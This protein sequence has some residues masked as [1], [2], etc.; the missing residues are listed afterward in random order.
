MP[1]SKSPIATN[2]DH[3]ARA[4]TADWTYMSGTDALISALIA[5][6]SLDVRDGLNT[7]GFVSGYRGSPVAGLDRALWKAS[8]AL[9]R[10][11]IT[12]VP[13]LNEELA[14]V[15]VLGS[16]KVESDPA[17]AVDGVFGLWYGKGPG[18][19]R[20]GDAIKHGNAYGASPNGGVL[21]VVGDDHGCVSSSMS[22]Q[23]DLALMG[24]SMP[25]IHPP[26]V[27]E[28]VSLALWGWACSRTSGCWL[29]FK[30]ISSVIESSRSVI[31]TDLPTFI[32]PII[33][34]DA[35]G[36]HW[37][38]PDLPST[39]IEERL[40]YKLAAARA[41]AASNPIDRQLSSPASTELVIVAVGKA[42]GD[43]L[44][45][46]DALEVS[47][48]DL[49]K[50]GICLLSV[51]LVF[52]LSPVLEALARDARKVLVV[53]EKAAVVETLLKDALFN[54]P[55]ERR[56]IIVGKVNEFGQPL[57]PTSEL[58]GSTIL[59]VISVF[60]GS[61]GISV[62]NRSERRGTVDRPSD[63]A[64]IQRSPYFCSGCPHNLSTVVPD[65]SRAYAGIGCHF[66]ANWMNRATTGIVP[67]GTEGADWVGQ[68]AFVAV[69]H[70][71]QNLGDGTYVHSG[72][73]AIRHA[74]ASGVNITYKILLNDAVAMTGGQPLE[75]G[76]S[77]YQIAHQL[78]A[79]GVQK[80]VVVSDDVRKYKDGSDF[81]QGVEFFD[82]SLLDEQQ[83]IL[84]STPGVTA[85]IYDQVCATEAQRR[86]RRSGKPRSS[87]RVIINSD[88]CEGCSDCQTK[89][90]CLS[91]V[92]AET[93]FGTKRQI[94]QS[95]CVTDA[96]CIE[97]YCPSFI[98][99]ENSTGLARIDTQLKDRIL[100]LGSSLQ[101]P[102]LPTVAS[103]FKMLICGIGGT[104][105]VTVSS[106]LAAA[107]HRA[108]LA[109]STQEYTGFAQKGGAV[110]SHI[111][112]AIPALGAVHQAQIDDEQADLIIAA[113]SIVAN[114]E[115][116]L[117]TINPSKTKVVVGTHNALTGEGLRDP[118]RQPTLDLSLRAIKARAAESNLSFFNPDETMQHVSGH[119]TG[120]SVCILGFAWQS[121]FIP[122]SEDQIM[123]AFAEKGL[124]TD[125]NK[126]AFIA[127]RLSANSKNINFVNSADSENFASQSFDVFVETRKDY[128]TDY[129]SRDYALKF[130]NAVVSIVKAS[131]QLPAENLVKT[132]AENLFRLM[133]YKDEYEVA[134]LLSRTP[135]I[136]EIKRQFGNGVKLSFFLAPPLLFRSAS[137]GPPRKTKFGQWI[138]PILK[139][140]A[141]LKVIRGT[142]LD[143]FGYTAER[144]IERS[145]IDEYIS[146]LAYIEPRL[147]EYNLASAIDLLAYPHE[148]RGYGHVKRSSIDR[149]REIRATNLARFTALSVRPSTT[150]E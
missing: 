142:P 67:M 65:G 8:S 101:P 138:L 91:I 124:L 26:S 71:F 83:R 136:T 47:L 50:A 75:V 122:L 76:L 57:I 105:I 9:E 36:L 133:A 139:V 127:G 34:S 40:S 125:D 12:F 15:S 77:A 63:A 2:T 70:V 130:E 140:L 128:L 146:L 118:K 99:I 56:P 54:A 98:K 119:A 3:V 126:I 116:V 112:F 135:A 35:G 131:E 68:S 108:G 38:W 10:Q 80:V 64:S 44:D 39:K 90:N 144:R 81:P 102:S 5:Q 149:A 17:K 107:A 6:R 117:R 28:Y 45:A 46:L 14:A 82:R 120:S 92:H 60:L 97:G 132:V 33:K 137:S 61:A 21:L 48:E 110:L 114:S 27:S 37:R 85:L 74:I 150:I 52:P 129:Q 104:G 148:I 86:L 111:R 123:Q 53:E 24:W 22:H 18:L 87:S 19:D 55:Y 69:D 23:S 89:S 103:S 11:R 20:A 4:D 59:D 141:T 16:Q 62:P 25:V 109:V 41:F 145:L 66:M 31:E 94:D 49:S 42:T 32:K 96:A 121:G 93:K 51:A 58:R 134:R 95:T 147:T 29:G 73:L 72:S 7:S 88:V 106:V 143:I 30:A 78:V 113:D 115:N 84:R 43:V 79:E 13:G 1:E 100:H